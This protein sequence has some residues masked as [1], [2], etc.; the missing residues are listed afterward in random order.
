[1][2]LID[3][4][5]KSLEDVHLSK[6]EKKDIRLILKGQPL[7]EESVSFLRSKIYELA[8]AKVTSDNFQFVMQWMK[9]ANNILSAAP[10][11]KPQVF[12]SPGDTCR[13]AII[14]QLNASVRE[15]KICVF[16]IS[17]D[18]ITNAILNAHRRG[19]DVRILTDND[20]SFDH[21]S[22]INQLARE[23]IS[24]KMDMSTNHMHHKFMV[25]DNKIVVTGSYNWTSSAAR[26]N[27]EN[28]LLIT[29]SGV[30]RSFAKEFDKLWAEMATY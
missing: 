6:V 23:G 5:K 18:L 26:F 4:L 7:D 10:A 30:V 25:A 13:N 1:M 2:D 8:H 24:V 19:I 20:K 17:D 3:H 29:E 11:E 22:D 14:G 15:L 27:H 28:I 12:F 9:D 21:G 16:T